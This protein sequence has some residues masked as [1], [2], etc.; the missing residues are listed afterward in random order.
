MHNNLVKIILLLSTVTLMSANAW[1]SP[2]T[3][4]A[5]TIP[6]TNTA[7]SITYNSS[8]H[9][10]IVAT[11]PSFNLLVGYHMDT[12]NAPGRVLTPTQPLGSLV[13][14]TWTNLVI[15]EVQPAISKLLILPVED[16]LWFQVQ[17]TIEV[18]TVSDDNVQNRTTPFETKA[19]FTVLHNETHQDAGISCTNCHTTSN[20]G[21]VTTITHFNNG[22][23]D[24]PGDSTSIVECHACHTHNSLQSF[25]QIRGVE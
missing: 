15:P 14:I 17:P 4:L 8:N 22:T 1:G 18:A 9:A 25:G 20:I 19:L 6:L 11:S 10:L 2:K 13:A 24:Q 16:D 5:A 21:A 23:I 3:M 12:Q 7:D